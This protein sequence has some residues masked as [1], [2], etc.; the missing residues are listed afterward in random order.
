MTV[1]FV[2]TPPYSPNFNLVEYLIHLF[3]LRLLHPD[4]K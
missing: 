1:E 3:R 2:Y 4:A